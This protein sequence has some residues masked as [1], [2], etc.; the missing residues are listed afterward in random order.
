VTGG[1]VCSRCILKYCSA[2]RDVA[3]STCGDVEWLRL[4]TSTVNYVASS[5]KW[6]F[7]LLKKIPVSKGSKR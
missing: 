1:F 5:L 2:S 6:F 7:N 4:L 3:D